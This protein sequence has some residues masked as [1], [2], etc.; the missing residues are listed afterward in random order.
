MH[1]ELDDVVENP[2]DLGVQFFAQ[3]VGAEGQLFESGVGGKS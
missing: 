1:F 2:F 3:G